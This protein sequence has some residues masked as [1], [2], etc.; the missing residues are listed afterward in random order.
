MQSCTSDLSGQWPGRLEDRA[1][2]LGGRR[3]QEN[4]VVGA[5]LVACQKRCDGTLRQKHLGTEM[6]V[7]YAAKARYNLCK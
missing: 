2:P 5:S 4:G 1:L 6:M 3:W 7:V